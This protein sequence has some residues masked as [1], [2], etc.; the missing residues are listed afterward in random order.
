MQAFSLRRFLQDLPESVGIF[1]NSRHIRRPYWS[2]SSNCRLV[3]FRLSF[4]NLFSPLRSAIS[5]LSLE[6]SNSIRVLI[7]VLMSC[8]RLTFNCW[9]T[10]LAI[11]AMSSLEIVDAMLIAVADGVDSILTGISLSLSI[12][13]S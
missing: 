5:L 9:E 12:S 6:V 4:N 8:I 10:A 13:V 7:S 11:S 2:S 3:T 1:E